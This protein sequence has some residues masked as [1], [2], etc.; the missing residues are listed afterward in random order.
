[1]KHTDIGIIGGGLVGLATAFQIKNISPNTT[2]HLIE[3]ETNICGHQSGH[4]SGVIHSGIYYKP[5]SLKAIN[6]R[7]GKSELINFC[8]R[9]NV[10]FKILGKLIV[11]TETAEIPTLQELLSRGK[12]NGVECSWVDSDFIKSNEP[13]VN[14]IQGIY[15]PEAGIIDY[16]GVAQKLADIISQQ[17]TEISLGSPVIK[18]HIENNGAIL[19]TKEAEIKC[20]KVINCAGLYSDHIAT[21]LG[22]PTKMKIIP[23]R[24]EYYDL[25]KEYLHFCKMPIYPV[26]NMNF[27]FLGVHLTPKIYGGTECG[28]NAV[29]A[30]AREGYSWRDLKLSELI[31]S[32]TYPGFLKLAGKYWQ[33]GWEE[34]RRSLSKKLFT[35]ALQRLIPEIQE[36]YLIPGGSGVRA[37]AVGIDGKLIDDFL[38]KE[39]PRV[40]NVLN[41]PS[42]G[43]TSCLNIGRSIAK[44]VL[45]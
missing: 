29:L 12:A 36:D 7:L 30:L 27:P 11:A 1:M 19:I 45:T 35:R 21:I 41:A 20:Q 25:K 42:P 3:K 34:I 17:G 8:E 37:Q 6:C 22:V 2:I 38:I 39:T 10:N 23:F 32:L 24:G 13:H 43:A 4:N 14:A 28:P 5:N 15:V 9:Y 44:T 40:I 26:P 16:P 31:E 33:E 18:C